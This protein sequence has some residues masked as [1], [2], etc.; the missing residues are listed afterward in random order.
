M[1]PQPPALDPQMAVQMVQ[2]Q[3]QQ[4]SQLV[5]LVQ[6]LGEM[7]AAALTRAAETSSGMAA[8]ASSTG[9]E[10]MEVDKDTGGV[11]HS[12]AESYIPKIPMLE[13][14]KMTTRT[15]EISFWSQYVEGVMSWLS[16]LDD[17]YPT[18][19]YR[20]MITPTEIQQSSLEKG[21]AARSARFL[22]LLRQSL[23][24]FQRAL[25]IVRQ[26]EQSQLGAACGYEAF[27]RLNTEFGVQ[28]R[29]EATSL[30]EAVL[31]FRP[32][33]HVV[34]PLDVYRAVESELL[35]ADRNLSGYSSLRLT[36]P[37]KMMLHLKCMPES[38]KHYVLLHGKSDTLNEIL[39]SIKFYDSHLRVIEHDKEGHKHSSRSAWTE[40]LIAA[41]NKGKGKKGKGKGKKGGKNEGTSE[42]GAGRGKGKRDDK[43]KAQSEGKKGKCFNCGQPGHFA[44]DCPEPRKDKPSGA[45]GQPK[46][47]GFCNFRVTFFPKNMVFLKSMVFPKNMVFL[48]SM[49][50]P[51]GM[52]FLKNMVV[53]S[54]A[55]K[56]FLSGMIVLMFCMGLNDTKNTGMI[57]VGFALCMDEYQVRCS[58]ASGEVLS[59]NRREENHGDHQKASEDKDEKNVPQKASEKQE[60]DSSEPQKVSD[61][62]DVSSEEPAAKAWSVVSEGEI[63]DVEMARLEDLRTQVAA[64]AEIAEFRSLEGGPQAEASYESH[65]KGLETHSQGD[66]EEETTS[67]GNAGKDLE[68]QREARKQAE[69]GASHEQL[70]D[71]APGGK[72]GALNEMPCTATAGADQG[73]AVES[74]S[75]SACSQ[76]KAREQVLALRATKAPA[77]AVNRDTFS[78]Q[79]PGIKAAWEALCSTGTEK[80][81]ER[82]MVDLCDLVEVLASLGDEGEETERGEGESEHDVWWILKDREVVDFDKISHVLQ[83]HQPF[84]S[85]CDVCVRSRSLPKGARERPRDQVMKHEVQI[86]H[87]FKFQKRFIVLVHAQSF[88]VGCVDG[89]ASRDQIL[90]N[91]G[92][93]LRYF[94]LSGVEV[95]TVFRCDA[96]PYM[97]ALLVE[98]LERFQSLH[99]PIEQFSPGRHAPAA[100][101]A[102]RTLRELGDSILVELQDHGVSLR[103]TS[104]AFALLYNHC[105]HVHN[106]YSQLAGSELSPLQRLRGNK[107]KPHQVYAFGSTVCAHASAVEDL[108]VGRFAFGC[109]LGP[110]M[111]K[112]SH[113]VNVRLPD[114]ALKLVQASSIKVVVPLRYDV[115][116]LGTFGRKV[117]G[118][119]HPAPQPLGDPEDPNLRTVPLSLVPGGNPPAEFFAEHG[120]TRRCTACQRGS[121]HAVNHSRTCRRRYQAWLK[122]EMQ[123][124]EPP[125]PLES[126]QG[127]GDVQHDGG[128][129]E[130]E[131]DV[132]DDL[133]RIE[134]DVPR[135]EDYE[136]RGGVGCDSEEP[137]Q[138]ELEREALPAWLPESP[139]PSED[140][141]SDPGVEDVEMMDRFVETPEPQKLSFA[142]EDAIT[143]VVAS[144]FFRTS[145]YNA[146]EDESWIDLE[147]RGRKVCLQR[148]KFVKDDT[149]GKPLDPQLTAEGMTKEVKALDALN[150]GDLVTK[151]EADEYAKEHNIRILTTRWVS[152]D[153]KE[154]ET[155]QKIVRSR[156]V[157]R[158]YASGNPTAQELGISSPTSSNEAFRTFL[159]FIASSGSDIILADVSTAFLFAKLVEELG[160]FACETEKTVFAGWFLFD[161]THYYMVLLAYVDDL[162]VGCRFLPAAKHFVEC[163]AKQVKIKVTGILSR[164]KK[165]EFLGRTIRRDSETDGILVGLPVGY[166]HSTYEAYGIRKPSLVPPDLRKILDDG[167]E[168]QQ[169]P[170]SAEASAKYRSAVGKVAWGAQTRIDLT[171]FISVLSRGQSQ[172][173]AVHEMCLRAFLRYLMSVEHHEQLLS[174]DGDAGTIVVY[175]DS[176]WASERNNSRRSLS[177]GVLFL[178]GAPVKAYTRQQTSIALSSAEAELTAICEG[179]KEALGLCVMVRHVFGKDVETP[180]VRSDSQA[181]INISSMFGLLR[182]VRHID[183]RL[184]W[185]QE[186]LREGRA[187]LEWVSGLENVSDIFT[188]STI[189]KVS[190][191]RH[192]NML[193]IVER[194]PPATMGLLAL[195]DWDC[196]Q[197]C[198]MLGKSPDLPVLL[199]LEQNLSAVSA[200]AH[201]LIVEFCTSENSNLGIAALELGSVKLVRITERENGVLDETIA[202]V[203]THVERLCRLGVNVLIWSSTP[204]TGGC[205]WQFTH[206]ERPGHG[207]YLKKVWGVQR[208]LWKNFEVICKPVED[209]PVGCLNPFVAI[210]WPKTCQYWHWRTT[211]KFG[212][213]H[214][215]T[216]MTSIVHGCAVEMRGRDNLLVKKQWRVDTD[217]KVLCETLQT[218]A[219]TKDHPH[220]ADFDLKSTQ[221]YPLDLCRRLVA[222]LP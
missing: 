95:G 56:F 64:A 67:E 20:A 195:E 2:A 42:K 132:P 98:L 71:G 43:P 169:Q 116:L 150:V 220:S 193:G 127:V 171:Y 141:R 24:D 130:V 77:G 138:P 204:C 30:R 52:V 133:E 157:V 92:A 182:R 102:V 178:D 173:L 163:L 59:L 106:R 79:K 97:R 118:G 40:E 198:R 21:P 44:R 187:K 110:M 218:F 3:S 124:N 217:L 61:V 190:Y 82:C 84:S 221:H 146:V 111:S 1:P 207:D 211:K 81:N 108:I 86:D 151:Q 205:L 50:F 93:W 212:F 112:T 145:V 197:L 103:S 128:M 18:E 135:D 5:G 60:A 88:A 87:F 117:V 65:A 210:E 55:K 28:S 107:H 216:L 80:R 158:D 137:F 199:E 147:I 105:C 176:N 123:P 161:G 213:D 51:K 156:V 122:G 27:R 31:Q 206:L 160:L 36:E 89:E 39:E 83:G 74:A 26:A 185:V 16:L 214:H 99:G 125:R 215:R 23:G 166:F 72:D 114:G 48:K 136:P 219:C 191:E 177:G 94:G 144:V 143:S 15:S 188:K 14:Q 100:E 104:R 54:M 91:M 121:T 115:E 140:P 32:G 78:P 200:E 6:T 35:K 168:S 19:L 57:M 179:M 33:K 183:I 186:A 152:V 73:R 194:L 170:L 62:C 189:Q 129:P 167:M 192:L 46:A 196:A 126:P 109:Y 165:V 101:R 148:P 119:V 58:L 68:G 174:C 4:I 90:E 155:K 34:R 201:W 17:F 154:G 13:Y 131:L 181:A 96:E 120:A 142:S 53:S 149:T 37:E 49:V 202:I 184:C 12:K 25:D 38:C 47:K 22:H 63:H 41:F 10:P 85:S 153:K 203:R 208:K 139:G 159:V 9:P 175:V 222:C 45:S 172:P 29:I 76:P 113:L 162:M 209:M 180:V 66:A 75:T 70:V 8:A 134:A 164:D 69:E 11:R 7:Q